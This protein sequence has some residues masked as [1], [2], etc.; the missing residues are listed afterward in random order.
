M[1]IEDERYRLLSTPWHDGGTL[2]IARS[3]AESDSLRQRLEL[4]LAVL[5]A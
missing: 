3:L 2:Q 5:I 4:R 1:P